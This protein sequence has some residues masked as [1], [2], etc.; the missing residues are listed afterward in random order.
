MA[1]FFMDKTYWPIDKLQ[2]WDKNP[3]SIKTQD[4][5]RLKKQ[6]E[7]LGQYKPLIITNDGVVLGGNMRLR[8]YKELGINDF[9]PLC[10]SHHRRLDS[11]RRHIGYFL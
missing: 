9:M 10:V 4:F 11:K 6:I 1:S 8:A 5:V 7:K 2:N 3:R